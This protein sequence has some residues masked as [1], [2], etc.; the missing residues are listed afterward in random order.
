M[1]LNWLLEAAKWQYL[2]KD[3]QQIPFSKSIK[4]VLIGITSG[5][6]TPNRI[7]EYVGRTYVL[8]KHNR[9]KGSLATMLGSLSQIM[10]TLILG[11]FGWFLLFNQIRFF[12]HLHYRPIFIA[13]LSVLMIF[14]ILLYYNLNWIKNLAKWLSINQKYID[15]IRF[16]SKYKAPELSFIMFLS[17]FR[18]VVFAGQYILFLKGLGV[19]IPL[20]S[21]LSAITVIFLIIVFIPHFSITE[22]GV[23]SSVAVLI[24][25]NFT[26]ELH[27][28]ATAAAILWLVNLAVPTLIG[29]FLL[30]TRNR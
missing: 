27:L 19:E 29:S 17:F 22:L 12:E 14:L 18:Y 13:L 20:L 10:I 2:L 25:Q 21:S 23:R 24:F 3:I 11:M 16:L 7:G 9:V 8:T 4:G 1:P 5:M 15:E 6:A 30:L 26:N 28:I